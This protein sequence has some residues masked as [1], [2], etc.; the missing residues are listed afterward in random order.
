MSFD[1]RA[2]H[3]LRAHHA[4]ISA[5]ATVAGDAVL[6][7]E[8]RRRLVASGQLERVVVGSY[9]FAG[10]DLDELARCAAVCM[11]RPELVVSGPTAARIWRRRRAP[12]DGLV[13]VIGPPASNPFRVAWVRTYRTATPPREDVVER[14]DGIRVTSPPRT[15]VDMTR[16]V[17][18]HDLESMIEHALERGMCSAATLDRVAR[19]LDRRGRPWVRRFLGVLHARADDAPAESEWERRV[20]EELRQRGVV[21]LVRQHWV[22]LPAHGRARFD[23]AVPDLRWALEVDVHPDHRSIAGASRDNR[24]DA[25]ADAAGWSVRRVAELQ[26]TDDLAAKMDDV[27]LSVQR[28]RN[29]SG[30]RRVMAQRYQSRYAAWCIAPARR[31]RGGGRGA[32]E[33]AFCAPARAAAGQDFAR[34][35]QRV[36]SRS[37]ARSVR[38]HAQP[39]ASGSSWR[40]AVPTR[41]DRGMAAWTY[42]MR[43]R[44]G[45]ARIAATAASPAASSASST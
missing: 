44:R 34:T 45:R 19:R 5:T 26:L 41:I 23:L 28:R 29:R 36:M 13:H 21:E 7:L 42:S 22:E 33:A 10:V 43:T 11:S 25:A 1:Q 31:A 18:A 32:L 15:V 37:P 8:V 17:P 38:R 6:L 39:S 30:T 20:H 35:R 2:L 27:A 9:A 24:R 14:A 40:H 3:W 4:T 12:H 16:Y